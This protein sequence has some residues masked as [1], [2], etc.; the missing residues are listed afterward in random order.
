MSET[1]KI[2]HKW[3]EAKKK[4]EELE[5]KIKRYKLDITKRMNSKE[6][7]KLSSNGYTVSRRRN[8]RSYV[9]KESLP[10]NLWKEYSTKC[11]YDSYHLVRDS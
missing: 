10:S 1:G 7:D 5:E 4:V 9:T 2:L 11:H 8:S 6:T 3:Y